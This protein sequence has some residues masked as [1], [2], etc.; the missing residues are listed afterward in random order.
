[1]LPT[2][3]VCDIA[4]ASKA[5]VKRHMFLKHKMTDQ[6]IAGF[7]IAV[8]KLVCDWC[9]SSFSNIWKH[10]QTCSKKPKS[11]RPTESSTT[12][13]DGFTQFLH[14]HVAAG[15]ARLSVGKARTIA[16]YWEQ[17]IDGFKI[18]QLNNALH[19]NVLF[20]SLQ[21][22]LDDS[23]SKGDVA[24]AIKTNKHMIAYGIEVFE[25]RY[26]THPEY[27]LQDK[28]TWKNDASLKS[29]Q[30]DKIQKTNNR[31]MEL[32]RAENVATD[33]EQNRRLEYNSD[34]VKQVNI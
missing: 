17:T 33:M 32:A 26:N 27:T 24:Q 28:V 30:F 11:A 5:V 19:N 16:T 14:R 21:S 1:M 4:L 34:R 23:Q 31:A 29:N 18:D 9:R 25:L 22:Y 3:P 20:P 15:T 12:F 10:K 6:E 8:A 2:C 13:L 7:K